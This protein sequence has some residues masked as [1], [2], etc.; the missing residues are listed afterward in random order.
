MVQLALYAKGYDPG[1][2]TGVL[3]TKTQAAL[4]AYQADHA[5]PQTGYMDT[6]TLLKLGVAP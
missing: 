6:A 2:M 4:R 1:P 5:L 3:N